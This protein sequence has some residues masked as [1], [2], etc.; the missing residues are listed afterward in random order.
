VAGPLD[1]AER[2]RALAHLYLNLTVV[3]RQLY[4]TEP[5]RGKEKAILNMMYGVNEL[6]HTVAT[7]LLPYVYQK[8]HALPLETMSQQLLEIANSYQITGLLD[9]AITLAQ[10]IFEAKPPTSN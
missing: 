9:S 3:V 6:H 7:R 2:A 4:L 10:T 1:Q 8:E 5:P